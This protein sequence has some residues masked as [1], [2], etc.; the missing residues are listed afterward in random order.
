MSPYAAWALS[1]ARSAAAVANFCDHVEHNEHADRAWVIDAG[2]DMRGL[3]CSIALAEDIDL[4]AAYAARLTAIEARNPLRHPD[5]PDGGA[6]AL[7]ATTWRELQLVQAEHDRFYHPDVVGLT[8][9]DQLRHY[10]LHIAKLVGALADAA[11]NPDA[12]QDFCDRRLADLLLFGV[13]LA[14]VTGHTLPKATL[15]S[16]ADE[17]RLVAA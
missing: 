11:S 4:R 13:K 2:R 12:G 3:A 5:S 17:R 15:V 8:K 14:T 6:I 9:L 16:R 1:L 7:Q 10:A